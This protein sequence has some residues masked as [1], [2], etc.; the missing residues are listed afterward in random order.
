MLVVHMR[1]H[2]GEKPHKCTVM[3]CLFYTLVYCTILFCTVLYLL[4]CNVLYCT[5]LYCTELNCT[6]LYCTVLYCTVLYCKLMSIV[7]YILTKVH[8]HMFEYIVLCSLTPPVDLE[9]P[10]AR[11]LKRVSLNETPKFPF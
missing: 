7:G 10:K 4:Y 2:T 11:N 6:V 9:E 5:V 3:H 1:R 8:N